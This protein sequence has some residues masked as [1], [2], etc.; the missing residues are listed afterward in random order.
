MTIE[1]NFVILYRKQSKKCPSEKRIPHFQMHLQ[2]EFQSLE[3]H[4][5]IYNK[6]S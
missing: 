6:L 5:K 3:N 4:G 2:N 1:K